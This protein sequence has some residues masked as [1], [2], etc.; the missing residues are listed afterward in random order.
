LI[1][2]LKSV[3]NIFFI[4]PVMA[5][6]ALLG[7]DTYFSPISNGVTNFNVPDRYCKKIKGREQAGYLSCGEGTI[8]LESLAKKRYSILPVPMY[9]GKKN[10]YCWI[11]SRWGNV[12]VSIATSDSLK[13]IPKKETMRLVLPDSKSYYP[14]TIFS[15]C[16]ALFPY[17]GVQDPRA[18]EHQV[19][20]NVDKKKYDEYS[21]EFSIIN[22]EKDSAYDY[23]IKFVQTR[24]LISSVVP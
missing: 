22:V 8:K 20:F 5:N 21:F 15:E 4:F 24:A 16:S 2:K 19:L 12:V 9:W 7:V 13:Y 23:S 18:K 3:R 14:T 17:N 6:C 11:N 10:D 1:M